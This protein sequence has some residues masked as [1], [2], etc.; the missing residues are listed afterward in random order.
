MNEVKSDAQ[1]VIEKLNLVQVIG[2]DG[3]MKVSGTTIAFAQPVDEFAFFLISEIKNLY[4]CAK[5]ASNLKGLTMEEIEAISSDIKTYTEYLEGVCNSN[6]NES[7]C[8]EL[9]EV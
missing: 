8:K 6:L 3:T 9:L 2:G 1:K 4:R 5:A 7:K